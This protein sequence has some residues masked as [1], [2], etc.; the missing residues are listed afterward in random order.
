MNVTMIEIDASIAVELAIGPVIAEEI[1]EMIDV[2]VIVL[3]TRG[4]VI[5][6]ENVDISLAIVAN[7]VEEETIIPA[8]AG[9][10][11]VVLAQD[12]QGGIHAIT[13]VEEDPEAAAVLALDLPEEPLLLVALDL[14]VRVLPQGANPP[15]ERE[16]NL[17]LVSP[18]HQ[19]MKMEPNPHATLLPKMIEN[20]LKGVQ[21]HL[22]AGALQD[23][24]VAGALLQN[25]IFGSVS[26]LLRG[27]RIKQYGQI[28]LPDKIG[29]FKDLLQ[30]FFHQE[31][32]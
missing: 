19:R 2:V 13:E 32:S 11:E 16:A 15:E 25:K 31:R 23:R 24:L 10:V 22:A 20:P 21:G 26:K 6:A 12:L 27:K 18:L 8:L 9:T 4:A 30:P 29:E 5:I 14:P 28:C 7:R 17:Q 3:A 1:G